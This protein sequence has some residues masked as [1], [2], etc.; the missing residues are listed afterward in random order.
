MSDWEKVARR[1]PCG[2]KVRVKCCGNDMS[3][4]ISH[5]EKGYSTYCFRCGDGS[6]Q[7]TPHG[8][9][10]LAD[11]IK[12]RKELNEY[13]E[14]QGELELPSDFDLEIPDYG[15]V[16][17][18]KGGVGAYLVKKYNIG[19]SEKMN[20]VVLPVFEEGTLT[21]VQSR[22]VWDAQQPKYL[23]KKGSSSALFW[24]KKKLQLERVSN[25][26]CITEDI[27]STIRVGRL[28]DCVST[29]G[30]ILSDKT[31]ARLLEDYDEFFIWYDGDEAGL[32]GAR[33]GKRALQM[34]GGKV[35][36]IKTELDPKE[37]NN[38]EIKEI[39]CQKCETSKD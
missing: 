15:R 10:S 7:F 31:A 9:R 32:R 29:L 27:L 33:K 30:T 13:M 6:R 14:E 36:L 2:R 1:L 24:A 22:S 12:H 11:M 37:Y 3:Q 35:H 25:A 39:L 18:L 20:R 4:I 5:S 19:W 17:L 26:L 34:Q 23:N 38:D 16:W 28:N 8:E 21:A